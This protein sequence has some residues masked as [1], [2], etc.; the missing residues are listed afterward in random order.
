M[1]RL[2]PDQYASLRAQASQLGLRV[3]RLATRLLLGRVGRVPLENRKLWVE[4]ARTDANLTQLLEHLA[5]DGEHPELVARTREVQHQLDA[6]RFDL[7][8]LDLE[9]LNAEPDHADPQ[10]AGPLEVPQ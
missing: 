7:L 3:G 10:G 2:S 8:G 4:L 1:L 9:T 6:L 5:G